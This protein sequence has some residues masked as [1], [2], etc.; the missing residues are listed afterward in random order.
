MEQLKN[1][2]KNLIIF[3]INYINIKCI[4]IIYLM[5]DKNKNDDTNNKNKNDKNKHKN[6]NRRKRKN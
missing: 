4:N 6:T 1:I 3:L 5:S 2:M